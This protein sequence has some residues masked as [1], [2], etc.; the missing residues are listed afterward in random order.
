MGEQ[1]AA[2]PSSSR[3]ASRWLLALTVLGVG[4]GWLFLFSASYPLSNA[5]W[6]NAFA[7]AMRQ[8]LFLAGGLVLFAAAALCP[9]RWVQRCA[10]AL[11]VAVVAALVATLFWGEAAGGA[12]RWLAFKDV[13]VQPSEFAK[14]TLVLALAAVMAHWWKATRWQQ[15]VGWW[16]VGV[17]LWVATVVL[18]AMQP[19]L[20]GALILGAVGAFALLFARMP[21]PVWVATLMGLGA[22]GYFAHSAVIHPYQYRR[23]QSAHGFV[24][25]D[26]PK[27]HY[28]SRQATLG[29]GAGGLFGRGLFQS[30]QKFLFLPSA[31]NDFVFAVIGEELGFLGSVGVVAFFTLL[32]Y[33]ALRVASGTADPFASGAAGGLGFAL[34]SQA[35]LHIAVN[36]GLLPPT[37]IPLPFVSAGGSSL[38]STL[39]AMGLLVN[40]ARQ[41]T[42]SQRRRRMGDALGDGGRGHR[43]AHLPRPRYRRR[44]SG[45]TA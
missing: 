26:D 31:H 2:L 18:V 1:T 42:G 20:S 9:F 15:Q 45:E 16:L 14:V 24:R 25:R 11:H 22:L 7:I 17:G 41:P 44:R 10:L 40:A 36:A 38:W 30:R 4:G 39:L 3:A 28:Q 32:A 23:L 27:M 8:L 6:G 5:L 35:M 12:A 43:G 21:L 34:W 33:W 37:G 29:L 13:R 19:H